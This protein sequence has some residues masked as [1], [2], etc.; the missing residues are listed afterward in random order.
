[1]VH[2]KSNEKVS[3]NSIPVRAQTPPPEFPPP[4]PFTEG[5]ESVQSALQQ[6]AQGFPS[7]GELPIPHLSPMTAHVPS[8]SVIVLMQAPPR[9]PPTFLRFIQCN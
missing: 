4:P 5:D 8:C 1:M 9:C 7:V 3:A 6:A 2:E